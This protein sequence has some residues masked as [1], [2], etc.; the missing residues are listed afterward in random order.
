MH[1]D[2]DVAYWLGGPMPEASAA[3]LFDSTRRA[4]VVNGWGIWAVQ[5]EEGGLVGAAGLQPVRQGLPG[6]P[7]VE[8]AWRLIPAARGKG[9][10]TRAMQA[11]LADG[12]AKL[13]M[14]EIVTFTAQTNH[15]SQAV[16]QR[17]GFRRDAARDFDHPALAEDHP[18]RRHV[19][20]AMARRR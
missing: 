3:A 9:L 14:P 4:L 19:F 11:V 20:Y 6:A 2:P 16:M 8:A 18:L 17:L 1:A 5:D 7:G 13:E 12:F 10:V 15:A